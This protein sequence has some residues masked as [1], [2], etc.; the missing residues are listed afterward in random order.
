MESTSVLSSR[1]DRGMNTC[2]FAKYELYKIFIYLFIYAGIGDGKP[3]T[4]FPRLMR[5]TGITALW[6]V[7]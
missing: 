5:G 2:C 7:S 6:T 1:Q 3:V 4:I